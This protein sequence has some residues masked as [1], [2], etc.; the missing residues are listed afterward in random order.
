MC[1]PKYHIHFG[2]GGLC[3]PYYIGIVNEIKKT[4]HLEDCIYSG[5]SVGSIVATLI[6]LKID[7]NQFVKKCFNRQVELIDKTNSSSK[8]IYNIS[9][10]IPNSIASILSFIYFFGTLGNTVEEVLK[11]TTCT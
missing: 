8:W 3:F 6:A 7:V 11:E 9:R 1:S 4:N 2:V 10:F 5:T